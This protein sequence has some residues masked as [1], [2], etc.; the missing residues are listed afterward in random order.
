MDLTQ[1]ESK[2]ESCMQLDRHRF[3]QKLSRLKKQRGKEG[4]KVKHT[5]ALKDLE[6]QILTSIEKAEARQAVLPKPE[7]PEE[8]PISG[9][10]EEI[11]NAISENQVVILC[12]ETGSG[13]S[14]QLP[15]ICLDMGRGVTGMIGHTQPR[16]I[17][18]RTVAARIA[19]ELKTQLGHHVGYK[20]RFN[21]HVGPQTFIKVMTDGILLAETQGD[22]F[23]NAYDTLIIDEAH[24]RS[25]NIDFLM[26]YLKTLLPKRPDLK[27]IITSATIDPER[28]AKHFND[29]PIIEVSGRTYP[30]E[31]RY[32]PLIE[33]GEE[34]AEI[35]LQ[36]G[37][38]DSVD[39]ISR[40]DQGDIL[41]F[42][43]GERDIRETTESLR[44]HQLKNTEVIPLYAKQGTAEQNKIFKAHK[45]RHIILAT[46][47][48]ETSLTVPG[49]R[50]VI[51]PGFAR[52]SR[53]SPRSKV[54]RLPIE[55]I[56]QASANQRMGRCGRVSEG[57]C[58]R[59]YSE[60]DFNARP[61]FTEPEI[62]RTSLASV[63]LQLS[64]LRFGD[65]E[66]FPFVEPPDGRYINDGYKLLEELG[67]VDRFRKLTETGRKLA[68]LPVDPRIGRMILA[69]H[70]QNCMKESLI[71]ASALS[72]QDV[73]DKPM[74]K[75]QQADEAHTK[76]ADEDSDFF[77]YLNLWDFYH[78]QMHHL[79]QNKMRKLCRTNF[80]NFMRLR[81]WMDI[82]GQLKGLAADLNFTINKEPAEHDSVHRSLLSGLLGNIGFLSDRK[83]YTGARGIKFF[84]FPG[85]GQFKKIPKWMMSTELVETTKLYARI[86][87]KIEPEWVIK[88]AGDLAKRSYSDAYWSKKAG[89]VL[90]LEKV[91]LYG[92]TLSADRK[93][94]Y[95]PI[96][97]AESR[98][99]F[100]QGALVAGETHARLDFFKHN[101][102][103]LSEIEAMEHR[104]RRLDILIDDQIQYDF[105]DQ[106]IPADVNNIR[107][108]EKW[109]RDV[110]KT[111]PEFLFFDREFLIRDGADEICDQALPETLSISG[112]NL[113]LSY[114]FEPGTK[115]DGVT[116]SVPMA[117]LNQLHPDRFDWLVP[118]LINEKITELIRSL[119]KQLRR[120]F[121][122]APNFAEACCNT[123]EYAEGNLFEMITAH[124]K[125]M[126]SIEVPAD[127]WDQARL[128]D[129]LH[130]NFKVVNT[131]GKVVSEGRNLDRLQGKLV[132]EVEQVFSEETSWPIERDEIKKWD[133]GELPAMV[134][135]TKHGM[136]L[137]GYPALIEG[138]DSVSIRVQD[139]QEKADKLHHDGLIKLIRLSISEQMKYLNKNLP[140]FEKMCLM[141]SSVGKKE[142]LKEDLIKAI[143][144]R[145]FIVGKNKIH[146]QQD[147]LNRV[148]RGR[149]EL[150]PVANDLSKLINEALK[151]YLVINKRISGKASLS[152]LNVMQDIK[153][154]VDHLIYPGFI[155]QTPDEWLKHLPRYLKAI[156]KRLDKID[157]DPAKDKELS[158]KASMFWRRYVDEK[159]KIEEIQ[160]FRWMIEEFRVSLF[161][162]ELGTH[163]PI[164]EKRLDKIWNEIK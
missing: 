10:R 73:R 108:L 78:D 124:L 137:R 82:H 8:L 89:R 70:D 51:D 57:I 60:D 104:S 30:V 46:N 18:A 97:P 94:N 56:S 71:I 95:G 91:V 98:R 17:A 84:I 81:E 20:I 39:E 86:N 162:Q 24:E 158:A 31:L 12:G 1:L 62:K 96:D 121:V 11:M 68:K 13:K 111:D 159:S 161:A 101:Q 106:K 88:I 55:N 83:E 135:T 76:F 131:N 145:V 40:T 66:E 42:L 35:D 127:A 152:W 9:K 141:F 23:L 112:M 129:H 34:E 87:A 75:L 54:Q 21:D 59:L 100:I 138:G 19:E 22:R 63:I 44:K 33:P 99:L 69:A 109:Y 142:E 114:H 65:I 123:V 4:Y 7:Y 156:D 72:V 157:R 164:S 154:Q 74:D 113:P 125:K 14:T 93:I 27:V 139:T 116:L 29:A 38:I 36:Q 163:L 67:A 5:H 28:F 146:S 117:V 52:I 155:D 53:Y 80:L 58:I 115:D 61:Q 90:A 105:Y 25:L 120:N 147:F 151:Q 160:N 148:D 133:F 43:S 143:I 140:E 128:A 126:T 136:P 118:G 32:R 150:I 26:G 119:P 16:R 48:A 110:E 79:S 64:S 2:L 103:L 132:D 47:V 41:I 3:R 144:D 49:I 102:K 45:K 77:W 134:E 37:I 122:P 50:Y 149:G 6:K 85:S 15:K 130:M 92:L 153:Q 107:G